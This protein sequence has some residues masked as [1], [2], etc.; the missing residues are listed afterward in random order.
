MLMAWLTTELT[1]LDLILCHPETH[2]WTLALMVMRF[3]D[4]S[5]SYD[6]HFGYW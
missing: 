4:F 6:E 2:R 3:G 1:G 5:K